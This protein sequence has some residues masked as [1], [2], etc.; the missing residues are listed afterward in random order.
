MAMMFTLDLATTTGWC[1]GAGDETPA[2]GH[3]RMPETKE[4]VGKFLD[5]FYRWMHLKVTDIM[6]E[7]G[8]D[9]ETR[10]SP[11]GA[12]LLNPR[13]LVIVFEAP[14]LPRAKIDTRPGKMGQLIQAPV[15]MATTRKLQGLAGVA[16]MVAEQ[17]NCLVEE[18]YNATIKKALG[19]SGS[20]DKPDMMAAAKRAGMNPKVHDEADAFGIWIVVM[21]AY[22]KQYQHIWDQRLYGGRGL[23]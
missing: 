6:A 14:V 20:A 5:F 17:R 8:P 23:V 10:P 15:T 2:L 19:G 3:I 9:L 4:E 16:E 12:Q 22:A 18:V 21:R 13:D 11:Y 7:M 1:F